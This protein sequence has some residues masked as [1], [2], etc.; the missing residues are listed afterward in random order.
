MTGTTPPKD[1][2]NQDSE[3][4]LM[5]RARGDD[6]SAFSQLIARHWERVYLHLRLTVGKEEAEDLTQETFMRIFRHRK[7][8]RPEAK[9]ITWLYSIVRNVARNA[10]RDR[11]RKPVVQLQEDSQEG[12]ASHLKD[13]KSETPSHLMERTELAIYVKDALKKLRRKHRAA[14]EGQHYDDKT[15]EEIARDLALTPQAAKSL[16]YRARLLMRQELESRV[17]DG[18]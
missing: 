6:N 11:R 10:L 12:Q 13:T 4:L 5:L 16:L 14:L 3:V 18:M 7:E 8:Y 1:Y 2:A 17:E 9:F 15:Y